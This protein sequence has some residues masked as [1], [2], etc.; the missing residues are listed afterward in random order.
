MYQT[1]KVDGICKVI[2]NRINTL[3]FTNALLCPILIATYYCI[4]DWKIQD[5]IRK[6]RT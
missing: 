1:L 5:L 3:Q 6:T 2:T 4:E